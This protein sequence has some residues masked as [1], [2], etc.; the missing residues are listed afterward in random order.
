MN[1]TRK[2]VALAALV[3]CASLTLSAAATAQETT[4]AG[5]EM[6][7]VYDSLKDI[8]KDLAAYDFA[9]GIGALTRLRAY[10]FSRK[11][12]PQARKEAE[13][14]L[15]DFVQSSPAPAPGGLMA[16]CRALSLIG[17]EASVP[18][19]GALVLKPGTTDPARYALERIPGQGADQALLAALDTTQGE[20]RR[21]VVFSLGARGSAAAVPALARLA[22][23]KDL[24][25]AS[26][27]V[28]A[29]GRIGGPEAVRALTTALGRSAAA[30]KSE[31]ASGLL[32]A[33]EGMRRDGD[34]AG[35]AAVYDKL[36]AASPSTVVRQA[37][38]KGKLACS[39][40][41]A[42]DLIL[43]ALAGKDAVLYA[44]A[45]AMVPPNFGTGEIGRV[46]DFF[47]A[48][49]EDARIQLT[50]VLGGY[51]ADA[52]RPYLFAAAEGPSLNLRLAALRAIERTGDAK[53]VAFL[54]AKAARSAG[55]EQET[56][57]ET[58]A[59]LKGADVDAAVLGHL[60][61]SS[62]DAIKGELI[63]AA[64]ARRIEGVKPALMDMVKTG[65]PEL[66]S[67]AAA[68]L[69]NVAVTA[70][71]P[72]LLGLL[73][74]LEDE[75]A[76]ESLQDTV[77]AVAR[78]NPRPLLRGDVAEAMLAEEKDPKKRVDLLRVLGKTGDDTALV[79]VRRALAD[80]D[81]AV[82]DA[83]VRALADWPTGTARDDVTEVARTSLNL[84]HRVLAV[85]ALVRMIGLEPYRA[86]EGA[87]SDLLNVLALTPRPEE[88][89][90]VLGM[91]V[92]F[93]CVKALKTAESLLSDQS[94]APEARLAADR[95]RRALGAR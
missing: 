46:A 35:A 92:R 66:R 15:L 73:L 76:R 64:S 65:R 82:A 63:Q 69:R 3:L 39:G 57:R 4:R 88:K 53:S 9:N 90:L 89:K 6:A 55:A 81:E 60:A 27:A 85:R 70:D 95:I 59:R 51:P 11:D 84:N 54:A 48:L 67:R 7:L 68:A 33:A 21:G 31:A 32:L 94:V 28:K 37:A 29:L 10:V 13:A 93:P 58:L 86:P 79:L 18:V 30:I 56:A 20:V 45:I 83:A 42:K 47:D 38:F 52:A 43:K 78:T 22:G 91:L 16:A 17:G 34:G 77:A 49:P 74:A 19:L 62:D 87:A 5:H 23:G 12:D 50:A 61:R 41:A 72:D 26:D 44:P 8:L 14:A 2:P 40:S 36:L 25:L 1:K 71:I 24:A 75:T 80:P